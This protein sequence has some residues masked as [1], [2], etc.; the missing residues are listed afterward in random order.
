M[1]SAIR[2]LITGATGMVGEGVLNA[3]LADASVEAVTV[4]NRRT[5]GFEHPRLTEI[6]HADFLNLSAAEN[7]LSG[8]DA[9]FFC[10]GVSSVG[11]KE[12]EYTRVTHDLTLHMA[13][14]LSRLNPGMTFCYVSGEGTDSSEKG[15]MMWA[16]VKGRT[17]NDLMKLPFRQ[18]FA[19]RPGFMKP[20]KGATNVLKS[21]KMLG[22]MY[23][24]L[25]SLFPGHSCTLRE[26]GKA[27]INTVR[28]GYEKKVLEV[29]DI[30]ALAKRPGY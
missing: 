24:L 9:C 26:V 7:S 22:W 23:P 15:R 13:D 11:M 10:L 1:N 5:C 20:D 16:R 21:Y 2:V 18:V 3:C 8:F 27:M 19:F 28:I 4:I 17:E 25:H 29:K 30:V 12:P 14:L 6:I